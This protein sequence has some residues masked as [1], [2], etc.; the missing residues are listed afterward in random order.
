MWRWR[1]QGTWDDLSEGGLK[2]VRRNATD[3]C[4]STVAVV[5]ACNYFCF[6][7]TL[8]PEVKAV[9]WVP[10]GF[11]TYDRSFDTFVWMIRSLARNGER[12]RDQDGP[13]RGGQAADSRARVRGH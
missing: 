7:T 10:L 12:R 3:D 13:A 6:G 11:L 4:G 8:R 1:T 5:C 9:H 2:R